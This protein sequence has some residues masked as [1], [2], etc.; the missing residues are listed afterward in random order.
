MEHQTVKDTT[1]GEPEPLGQR[2]GYHA[3]R[4][5]AGTEE[6][7]EKEIRDEEKDRHRTK[8]TET[9]NR[10]SVKLERWLKN[11]ELKAKNRN[12]GNDD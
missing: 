1:V 9:K 10:D 3:D 8:R 12:P 4:V 2:G 5:A 7:D 6:L 11:R